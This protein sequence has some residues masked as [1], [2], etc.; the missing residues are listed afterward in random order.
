MIAHT[1]AEQG[2]RRIYIITGEPSGDAHAARVVHAIRSMDA[3]VAFRGMGGDAMA[4]AGVE[5]VEHVRNTAIM[6]FAEVVAK[7]SFIRGLLSRVKADISAFNPDRILL[8]DYP[9]FNLRMATWARQR[10]WS[11]DMY[12]APQVWAWKRKRIHRMARD[13]DRLYVILPFEARCYDEVELEVQFVGHPL[14]DSIPPSDAESGGSAGSPPESE[15][16][17]RTRCGLPADVELL[18][19]LP[20]S[21]PQ[22]IERLLPC[23]VEAADRFPDLFPVVAG[24]PPESEV[25]WRTRCGLPADVELLALLPGSRPQEIERLL[26]CLVEA[27]DRFPDLFPVVAGAPGR[28]MTDYDTSLPVLFGE[29]QSLYRHASAGI[30]TSGTATLEAALHGL[31]QVVAYSTSGLTYRIAKWFSNVRFI[32]LVNLVLNQEAVPERIQ[33]QCT[34][35]ILADTLRYVLSDEGRRQQA[36]DHARLRQVLS[37]RGAAE[38]VAQGLMRAKGHPA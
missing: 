23:L 15:V 12:I 27:A 20:G 6:G 4:E 19:L 17:W 1:A 10:G 2:I 30:I 9:G 22:E 32:S 25:A 38:A 24:S 21:R 13:L 11:V 37:K 3:G 36:Q 8:V 7:L 28:R 34:P 18:A 33:S 5:L 29:T 26:P 14:A 35:A 31:P 16:A